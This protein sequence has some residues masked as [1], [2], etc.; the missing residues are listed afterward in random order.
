MRRG[1]FCVY[2]LESSG[3]GDEGDLDQGTPA[4]CFDTQ[5]EAVA[6]LVEIQRKGRVPLFDGRFLCRF[7][8]T[9]KTGK[10]FVGNVDTCL[11]LKE[12]GVLPPTIFD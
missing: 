7:K 11:N 6:K 1:T 4:A 9:L 2:D 5:A 8:R 12:E 3:H 10:F